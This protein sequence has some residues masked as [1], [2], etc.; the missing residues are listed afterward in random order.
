MDSSAELQ[1]LRRR[2]ILGRRRWQVVSLLAMSLIGVALGIWLTVAG[3]PLLG[4]LFIAV[5][6]WRAQQFSLWLVVPT[7]V[8]RDVPGPMNGRWQRALL[9]IIV[10][11]G[12]V[13][14]GVGVYLC[15]MWPEDW[16]AGLVF[17]LFGLIVLLPV[18]IRE[19]Q[20]RRI[21]PTGNADDRKDTA[22]ADSHL[23]SGS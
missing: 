14:C 6:L 11:L 23:E 2:S 20:L 9:S 16:Q 17:V 4:S 7:A 3:F 13:I 1:G 8:P 22:V 18:T 10:L 5:F 19:V 15:Q 12:A 21:V